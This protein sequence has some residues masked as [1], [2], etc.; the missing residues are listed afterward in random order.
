M[1][2]HR[3]DKICMNCLKEMK[4]NLTCSKCMVAKY[5]NRKCQAAHWQVHKHICQDSSN[6]DDVKDSNNID[7]TNDIDGI[8]DEMSSMN[9]HSSSKRSTKTC[10]NCLKEVESNEYI[11]CA[12]CRVA[13]YCNIACQ[14]AHWKVHKNMCKDS[15]SDDSIEKL[16]M[17]ASNCLKQG[18]YRKA[19]KL[20]RKLLENLTGS[21]G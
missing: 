13:K 18:N 11:R 16:E 7:D 21:L 12:D 20:F 9:I 8:D 6:S 2:T 1:T 14:A 5:C 15:N 3:I 17:K 10:M 19:E 4:G